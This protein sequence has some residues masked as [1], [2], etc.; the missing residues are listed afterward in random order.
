MHQVAPE[1]VGEE[2]IKLGPCPIYNRINFIRAD[3]F[4]IKLKQQQQQ[5]THIILPDC[6]VRQAILTRKPK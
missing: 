4:N 5:S 6:G 3:I 1:V 2:N